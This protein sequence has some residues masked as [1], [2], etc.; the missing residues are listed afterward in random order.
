MMRQPLLISSLLRHADA[1]HGDTEVVTRLPEGGVHRYDYRAAHRRARQLA[2]ALAALGVQ[3]TDR[4]GTLAWNTHRHFEIYYAAS[5]SGAVV[6]TINPRLS[7][8]Q[9]AY[10]VGHADD[11]VLFFDIAFLKQ[12]EAIAPRC[13]H[14][15][16]WIALTDRAHLPANTLP[17]LCYEEVVA[18]ESDDFE[19]PDLDELAAAAL[20][21][22]SGTTG[23]PKGVLYTHRS[24]LL[25]AY[26]ASLP[27]SLGLSARDTVLPVVP[28]FHVNAWGIP[29]AAPLTGAK[30]VFPGAGLDGAS[31][32]ELYTRERVTFSCGVPT[33]W[34]GV[35]QHLQKSGQRLPLPHRTVIGGAALPT[36][37]TQTLRDDHGLEVRHGWGMTELSPVGVVNTPRRSDTSNTPVEEPQRAQGRV[38]PGIDLCLVDAA[39]AAVPHDGR[40][41]GELLARGHWV[42]E[43]YFRN[44]GGDPL[45]AGGWFPTGDIATIDADGYLRIVDRAKD[46]VK[47]GGEWISSIELENAVLSH[48]AIAQA[49]VIAVP[50]EKW[51]ER[52]FVI[53]VCKPD[54]ATSDTE[55]L[56]HLQARVPKWWMPEGVEFVAS[57]P[58]SGTGKVLK[59]ELRERHLKR[60]S[61]PGKPRSTGG[62]GEG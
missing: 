17:L 14:V 2:R 48:P 60:I 21:Y 46:L 37:L 5:G 29:Y 39:G 53:A 25:H 22:T 8:D 20:C 27:D 41:R 18:G 51:G 61:G 52:P 58:F 32:T 28:M 19:W 62:A 13:A 24:T 11:R 55:I 36:S 26:A 44:E 15:R 16:H 23:H 57:L 45:R 59:R 31:L 7:L 12:V 43:G 9:L 34:L 4:V 38:L 1:W 54:C 10:I 3:R 30:L 40:S 56:A 42:C 35:L 6:H 49:A 33:I 50:H 47:S